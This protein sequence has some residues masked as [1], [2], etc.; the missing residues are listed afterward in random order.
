MNECPSSVPG[1]EGVPEPGTPIRDRRALLRNLAVGDIFHASAPNGASLICLVTAVADAIVQA[2]TVTHEMHLEFD[3]E[4]GIAEWNPAKGWPGKGYDDVWIPCTMDS[5]A[6]LPPDVHNVMLFVDRD[7][8]LKHLHDDAGMS[9]AE[10]EAFLFV[11][12]YYR[13]N[14]LP[15]ADMHDPASEAD[16]I[17]RVL[18]PYLIPAQAIAVPP[19]RLS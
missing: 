3:R 5:V 14:P 16:L 17:H 4:T 11:Y 7:S 15:G 6:P 18:A 1:C 19:S 12:S 2:R 10:K 13:E 9:D 8:R